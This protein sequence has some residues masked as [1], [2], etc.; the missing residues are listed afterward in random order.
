MRL[1]L[2][3][4]YGAGSS[5]TSARSFTTTIKPNPSRRQS[6]FTLRMFLGPGADREIDRVGERQPVDPL[7]NQAEP[8]GT[9]Q[10]DDHRRLAAAHADHVTSP[11]FAFTLYPWPSSSA[12]TGA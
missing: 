12:F 7:Q 6:F 4:V 5:T 2:R 11:H 8:E 10:L 1:F 9:L 3:G